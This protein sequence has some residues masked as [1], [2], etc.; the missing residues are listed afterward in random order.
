M[1]RWHLRL[2]WGWLALVLALGAAGLWPS[3]WAQTG[4]VPGVQPRVLNAEPGS[5]AL[6]EALSAPLPT[7]PQQALHW[8]AALEALGLQPDAVL[9]RRFLLQQMARQWSGAPLQEGLTVAQALALA[10]GWSPAAVQHEVGRAWQ[11]HAPTVLKPVFP[12]AGRA[13]PDEV[14]GLRAEL[15]EVRPGVWAWR[16]RD[17]RLRGAFLDVDLVNTGPWPV[18]LSAFGWRVYRAPVEV[19]WSCLPLREA[20]AAALAPAA[21]QRML[22]RTPGTGLQAPEAVL[23]MLRALPDEP[24]RP[25]LVVQG[26]ETS[27]EQR[28]S[29]DLLAQRQDAALQAFVQRN[30]GCERLGTCARIEAAAAARVAQKARADAQAQA[31]AERRQSEEKTSQWRLLKIA[32]AGVFWHFAFTR[33][34]GLVVTS[35]L[36]VG[37]GA[38]F[39]YGWIRDVWSASY[40]DSW[41]GTVAIPATLFLAAAPFLAAFVLG[42]TSKLLGQVLDFL[43]ARGPS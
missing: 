39:A 9:M 2:G 21:S 20:Q 15:S 23:L 38:V 14:E 4:V 28:R 18:V 3:A 22:C 34:V 17:G 42:L 16:H 26:F 7:S 27:D 41:G 11:N 30:Q 32:L 35:F 40:A 29:L 13:L 19:E 31:H 24:G 25:K 5:P 1:A 43:R 36:T 10:G 33:W 8:P 12:P 37:V 6:L